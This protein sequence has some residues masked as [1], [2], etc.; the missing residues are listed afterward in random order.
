MKVFKVVLMYNGY[1]D[2][3]KTASPTKIS[4]NVLKLIQVKSNYL[5]AHLGVFLTMCPS[6]TK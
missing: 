1:S 3:D 4:I 2:R 5:H 6:G